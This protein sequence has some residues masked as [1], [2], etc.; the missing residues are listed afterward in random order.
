MVLGADHARNLEAA[1]DVH[2][3][4]CR[5]TPACIEALGDPRNRL[6][7][8]AARLRAGGLDPVRYRDPASGEWREETP[9]YDHLA[10]VLRMYAY[11][12]LSAAA[13]ALIIHQADEGDYTGLLA[14][15]RMMSRDMGS[16]MATG[17]HHSVICAEDADDF[18]VTPSDEDTVLG[19]MLVEFIRTLCE[20]WPRGARPADFRE[21]LTGDFPV[22]L[23]SGEY[24]PVT[25]PRY[26]DEVAAHLGNARH[27]V[28]RGQGHS[29]MATGCMPKLAAQFI[30]RADAADLD[31][32]CLDRLAPSPPFSGLHGWEP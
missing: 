16:Q 6:D 5:D 9:T 2:F 15:M 24:D 30:E 19:G 10:G 32:S 28:L 26:G 29:L 13:L 25:P 31:V 11:S 7:E 18:P 22:L 4:R 20:V 17:M 12:P 14:M 23:V 3:Q 21:P 1:L 27:L 8:V